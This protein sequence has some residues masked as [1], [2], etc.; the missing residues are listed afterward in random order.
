VL[1]ERYR[2][3]ELIGRGGMASVYRGQDLTLGRQ[4]AIKILKRELAEDS[5]FR[6]RFRLEAQSASRMSHPRSSASTTP[7]RM[8]RPT[9][10]LDA[11]VPY[12]V[13]ELVGAPS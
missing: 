12:I 3:D 13:M 11:P 8:P 6:T 2:V 7:V 9:R 5:A 10:R 1:S 4:V